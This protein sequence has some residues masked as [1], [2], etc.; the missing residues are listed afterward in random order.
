[1]LTDFDGVDTP[2]TEEVSNNTHWM[3]WCLT[4]YDEWSAY[5]DYFNDDNIFLLHMSGLS[6]EFIVI[7]KLIAFW[8]FFQLPFVFIIPIAC[9]ILEIG[10]ENLIEIHGNRNKFRCIGCCS[11]IDRMENRITKMPDP[12]LKCGNIMRYSFDC[13]MY[14]I[15]T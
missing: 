13:E 15:C 4:D 2:Q 3:D 5:Q 8:F 12:C 10:T 7:I 11:R 9:L 14:N 6:F 1:M